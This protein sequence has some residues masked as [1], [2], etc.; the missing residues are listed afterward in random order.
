MN[1]SKRYELEQPIDAARSEL[2]G[3]KP[4]MGWASSLVSHVFIL[5][6]AAALAATGSGCS[7]KHMAVNSLGDAL[8]GSGDVYAAD[9]DIELIGAASPFGLKLTESLLAESPEHRGLLLAA[10]R[11]FTQYAYAYVASPADEI[12]KH[13]VKAAYAQRARAHKLYLRA[14]DYG[15][16]GL[17][18]AHSGLRAA[19]QHDPAGA[20]A[21]TT[22]ADVALLHWTATA[23]GAAIALD[24][25]SPTALGGLPQV[26]ALI[27]RAAKLDESFDAGAI[28]SFLI[29]FEM[30]R[31]G[32]GRERAH[33]H[34]ERAV[35]LSGGRQAAPY[36]TYAESVSA[37][38]ANRGEYESLLHR[39]L[40]IDPAAAPQ[41][42][43]T[44]TV[45]QRRARWL[46]ANPDRYFID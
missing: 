37:A 22:K 25:D 4:S 1:T 6:A 18:A 16:R 32:G 46:L 38:S 30:S 29:A 8:A 7:I 12:E 10:A 45:Y 20:L 23:W 15:L 31:P 35:E 26:A 33:R 43:L 39:A 42:T 24:K 13:D 34:F 5:L 28:H 44:N 11:G 17:E 27:D 19:L 40:D 21:P 9:E 3:T 41:W 2:V 14:R 36:V